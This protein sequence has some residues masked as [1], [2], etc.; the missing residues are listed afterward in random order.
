M[1]SL[2]RLAIG[3][4]VV[5]LCGRG[6]FADTV[7]IGDSMNDSIKVDD[8]KVEDPKEDK[9]AYLTA[10][11]TPTSKAFSKLQRISIDGETNFNSAEEAYA[12]KDYD[13]A[14]TAYQAVL[15]SGSKPWMQVRAAS[16]VI[17]VAKVKN[18]YDAEIAAYVA[19]L[20]S[21]PA[22]AAASKP[23]EPPEHS[24]YLDPA[25]ASISKALD[26]SKLASAQK[27]TLL[28]LQLQ[29]DQTK[30]D[31][32]QVQATLQ[33]LVALGGGND[34]MKATLKLANANVAYASKQYSQA[35]SDIEQNKQLFTEPDQQVDALFVLAQAKYAVDGD[36]TDPEVLKDLAL[37]Y[38]R[39]VTFSA[40]LAEQPH[41]AESLFQT[42]A[43]E[44]KLKDNTAALQL[45]S[46]LAGNRALASSPFKAKADAAIS[47][48]RATK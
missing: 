47:R 1:N 43:I 17:A 38:M 14:L 22:V 36:K 48:L 29:I 20:Q 11:G 28:N 24:Q 45:Y 41:M 32:A 6:V 27:S 40:P 25:L 35:I 7:W 44:E 15:G 37:N 9:L 8:V 19:L 10:Q 33:Q 16:R 13:S 31:T 42:A 21:D 26:N 46:Q 5:A 4:A 12:N 3:A 23:S 18:R 2:K 39:V 34:S 30:G